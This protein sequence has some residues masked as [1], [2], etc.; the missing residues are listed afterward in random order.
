ML[1][2]LTPIFLIFY[3]GFIQEVAG[4]NIRPLSD[5][6]TLITNAGQVLLVNI[7]DAGSN[8]SIVRFIYCGE[9]GQKLTA[10]PRSNFREV[11]RAVRSQ[12]QEKEVDLIIME[13]TPADG[14]VEVQ[15]MDPKD[16][17]AEKKRITFWSKMAAIG[18]FGSLF[19]MLF[20]AAFSPLLGL[21]VLPLS[22][23]GIVFA[24]K[25]LKRTKRKPQYKKQRRMSAWSMALSLSWAALL[26]IYIIV[27]IVVVFAFFVI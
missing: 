22:I 7:D 25:V 9:N 12:K 13:A 14:S 5:C 6:D 3:C 4:S 18:G 23:L 1:L 10:Q 20:S 8:D 16:H 15:Y 11:R 26:A 2:R 19:M 24:A 17:V 27:L 21:L